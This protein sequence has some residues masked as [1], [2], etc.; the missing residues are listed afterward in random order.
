MAWICK[1]FFCSIIP[2]LSLFW[3]YTLIKTE[4]SKQIPKNVFQIAKEVERI[5]RAECILQRELFCLVL[6]HIH[7]YDNIQH[8]L[9]NLCPYFQGF[10]FKSDSNRDCW[11]FHSIDSET[12]ASNHIFLLLDLPYRFPHSLIGFS[13]NWQG[14]DTVFLDLASTSSLDL[15][16]DWSQLVC[17]F[18]SLTSLPLLWS[19]L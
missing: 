1:L 19:Q 17:P 14:Q 7:S 18:P 13:W 4:E 12:S 2:F 16:K 8:K 15:P 10:E 6:L 9:L 5:L 3:L 11:N